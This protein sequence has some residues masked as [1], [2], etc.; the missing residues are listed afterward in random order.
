[1]ASLST[2]APSTMDSLPRKVPPTMDSFPREVKLMILRQLD[3]LINPDSIRLIPYQQVFCSHTRTRHCFPNS[4]RPTTASFHF[5]IPAMDRPSSIVTAKM[6]GP[7]STPASVTSAFERLESIELCSYPLDDELDHEIWCCGPLTA[8]ANLIPEELDPLL[9]APPYSQHAARN[10]LVLE[11][12]APSAPR[13]YTPGAPTPVYC[14]ILTF[15]DIPDTKRLVRDF[16]LLLSADLDLSTVKYCDPVDERALARDVN[17]S[18][19]SLDA[20]IAE[21]RRLVEKEEIPR[22]PGR[23]TRL[24]R[25]PQPPAPNRALMD[26]APLPSRPA[27]RRVH[28][29]LLPR[30][31]PR[32]RKVAYE[33]EAARRAGQV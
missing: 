27:R 4:R 11:W 10:S 7:T 8:F 19:K 6:D 1:M 13:A 22:R 18:G 31:A 33:G 15:D 9:S 16:S 29:L 17:A 23:C 5:L 30:V 32:I 2:E 28:H 12:L 21:D 3:G 25:Q 20:D 26:V 14:A 24:R